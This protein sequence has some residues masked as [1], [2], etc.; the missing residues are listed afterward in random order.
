M[1]YV[2]LYVFIICLCIYKYMK[3]MYCI[4]RKLLLHKV[5]LFIVVVH[6][7]FYTQVTK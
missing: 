4:Y 7:Y 2:Y 5:F 3:G 1:V 6:Y